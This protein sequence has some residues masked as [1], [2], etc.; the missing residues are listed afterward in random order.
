MNTPETPVYHKAKVL[1]GLDLAKRDIARGKQAVVVEG[2]TDGM[3]CHLAGITTAVATCGT[4]FGGDHITML[5]RVMG[6]TDN[7]DTTQLGE[8]IF[9]FDPDE[10]GQKAAS[11]TSQRPSP[12]ASRCRWSRL[13]HRS[14][15][16]R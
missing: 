2:Y 3:A 1:Y 5:R 6:D 12:R 16:S 10:A 7:A 14:T 11:R 13:P 9:T 4:A 8:V 15:T